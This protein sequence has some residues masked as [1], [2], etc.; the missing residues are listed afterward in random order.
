VTA[1]ATAGRSPIGRLMK[2]AAQPEDR[3]RNRLR[4]QPKSTACRIWW[5]R[6][7]A[8]HPACQA[9]FS[10]LSGCRL[11]GDRWVW[12]WAGH[13]AAGSES[14]AAS[15][16]LSSSGRTSRSLGRPVARLARIRLGRSSVH[17]LRPKAGSRTQPLRISSQPPSPA[18]SARRSIRPRSVSRVKTRLPYLLKGEIGR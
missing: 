11:I 18:T 5:D 9:F 2:K 12:R 1:T 13:S 17:T 15:R 3:R 4:H 6:H 14:A 10:S 16:R 7:P 8:G